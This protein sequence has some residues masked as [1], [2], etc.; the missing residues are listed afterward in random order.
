M[1]WTGPP[2]LSSG[3]PLPQSPTTTTVSIPA[4]W[5][6][7][8]TKKTAVQSY[9]R[10]SKFLWRRSWKGRRAVTKSKIRRNSRT[11]SSRAPHLSLKSRLE[12]RTRAKWIE[13]G[14]AHYPPIWS[15]PRPWVA[16]SISS[17]RNSRRLQPRKCLEDRLSSWLGIQMKDMDW[18]G[19]PGKNHSCWAE[20][21]TREFCFGISKPATLTTRGSSILAVSTTIQHLSRTSP[22]T[23]PIRMYSQAA[24]TIGLSPYGTH[25][26]DTAKGVSHFSQ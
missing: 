12:L 1:P 22:G 18:P 8:L 25:G 5:L 3:F 20:H 7:M 4:C 24:V 2:W 6:Q 11:V 15:P 16:M 19:I 10:V 21:T 9:W 17:I 13:Q 14:I 26:S 23:K